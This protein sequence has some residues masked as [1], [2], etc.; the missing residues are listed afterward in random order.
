LG[1]GDLVPVLGDRLWSMITHTTYKSRIKDLTSCAK[2]NRMAGAVNYVW[3][4]VN[5]TAAKA[6]RRD[7]RW[8]TAYDM[9]AL[10]SGCGSEL[11]LHSQ[12]VQKICSKH[13]TRRTQYKKLRLNWRC[14]KR[15]LGWVPFKS[16]GIK[17]END[18]VVYCGQT[19][20]VWLSRKVKGIIKEGSFTQDAR[21]RWYVNLQCE[22]E[23]EQTAA[24]KPDVGI[25]LG[26]REQVVLSDGRSFARDNLTKKYEVRLATAQRAGKQ[27]QTKAI[28]AKIAHCRKDWAHKTTTHI[29]KTSRNIFVGNVSS[30]K[31][32]KTKFAKSVHDAGWHQTKSLLVYKAIRLGGVCKDVNE[33]FSTVTCSYCLKRTGPSGLSALGVRRWV[34]E[35]CGSEHDRNVN[36]A[37]NILGVGL[38]R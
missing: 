31:L 35:R 19:F 22:I 13:A 30:K 24:N 20:R 38:G 9:Q 11:G 17:L 6:Y 7:H 26:L 29:A 27:K 15:S 25:D 37:R 34:C 21:G 10:T 5:E 3:N 2:L 14:K 36:A 16:S 32:V 1:H 33:S 18:A 8:L 28:H 23:T 12:T 4:Y